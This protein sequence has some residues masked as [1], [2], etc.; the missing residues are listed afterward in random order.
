MATRRMAVL[1]AAIT[2]AAGTVAQADYIEKLYVPASPQETNYYCGVAVVQMWIDWLEGDAPSQDE[3]ADDQDVT[4]TNGL[5]APEMEDALED[6]S[7]NNF[8]DVNYSTQS[9]YAARIVS[10]I[11]DDDS[12][13][14]VIANTRR[15]SGSTS[16]CSHW[17]LV[18]GFR[19]ST[20]TYSTSWSNLRGFYIKDPLYG[21]AYTNTYY[22]ISPSS[23]VTKETYFSTWASRCPSNY[24]LVQD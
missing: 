22:Y 19:L 23:Y 10:E 5:N 8:S 4:S 3:I 9:S 12:P 20:S 7:W 18:D 13:A 17:L 21:S 24:Y 16:S 15:R 1:L 14:A 2:V 6:Y 11:H